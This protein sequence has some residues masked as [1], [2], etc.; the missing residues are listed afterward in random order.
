MLLAKM[1]LS[2]P[3]PPTNKIVVEGRPD[4]GT[5]NRNHSPSPF[6]DKLRAGFS[7]NALNNTGY[8]LVHHTFFQQIAAQID[9][10]GAGRRNPQFSGFL[11][12]A[13]LETVQ[14]T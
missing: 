8:E 10:R 11:V 13:E 3:A 2:T 1:R 4:Q 9:A 14:E 7:R 6:L 12:G 5:H